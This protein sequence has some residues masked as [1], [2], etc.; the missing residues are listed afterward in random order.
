METVKRVTKVVLGFSGKTTAT[1][2]N[3]YDAPFEGTEIYK[4]G[5]N[6]I[7]GFK[8]NVYATVTYSDNSTSKKYLK[9]DDKLRLLYEVNEGDNTVKLTAVYPDSFGFVY[10]SNTITLKYAKCNFD[11]ADHV[12]ETAPQTEFSGGEDLKT[13]SGE[14]HIDNQTVSWI[15][16]DGNTIPNFASAIFHGSTV[17]YSKPKATI[18]N[19]IGGISVTETIEDNWGRNIWEK[20]YDCSLKPDALKLDSSSDSPHPY[21]VKYV[22]KKDNAIDLDSLV[23]TEFSLFA[24]TDEYKM[25]KGEYALSLEGEFAGYKDKLYGFIVSTDLLGGISRTFKSYGSTPYGIQAMK[26][27]PSSIEVFGE[28]T[29]VYYDTYVSKFQIP[30]SLSFKIK[31]RSGA[32]ETIEATDPR[33]TYSVIDEEGDS[34]PADGKT[35]GQGDDH[36]FVAFTPDINLMDG[37]LGITYPLKWT[38][39]L[40]TNVKLELDTSLQPKTIYVDYDASS[41]PIKDLSGKLVSDVS[42]FEHDCDEHSFNYSIEPEFQGYADVDYEV[43]VTYEYRGVSYSA[44]YT[45]IVRKNSFSISASG[46]DDKSDYY[47]TWRTAFQVPTSI[48]FILTYAN[49][50]SEEVSPADERI[51]YYN[52]SA[53]QVRLTPSSIV[54]KTDRIYIAFDNGKET[55]Y[56]SYQ[57]S[58]KQDPLEGVYL[59]LDTDNAPKRVFFSED[60]KTIDYSKVKAYIK[61][62]VEKLGYNEEVTDKCEVTISPSINTEITANYVVTFSTEFLGDTFSNS[63]SVVCIPLAISSIVPDKA[64]TE[65]YYDTWLKPF[66]LPSINF[67]IHYNDGSSKSVT[68][69]YE[70]FSFYADADKTEVLNSGIIVSKSDYIYFD[71]VDDNGRKGSGRYSISANRDYIAALS[72]QNPNMEITKGRKPSDYAFG[73]TATYASGASVPNWH[74]Y[75]IRNSSSYI[76]PNDGNSPFSYKDGKVAIE[77]IDNSCQDASVSVSYP[78]AN[79]STKAVSI[80]DYGELKTAINKGKDG[81]DLRRTKV[82]VTYYDKDGDLDYASVYSYGTEATKTTFKPSSSNEDVKRFDGTALEMPSM[83]ANR[84][85]VEVTLSAVQE[86]TGEAVSVSA[87]VS[88]IAIANIAYISSGKAINENGYNSS[89]KTT[90]KIGEKFADS[91]DKSNVFIGYKDANGDIDKVKFDLA[92]A[93]SLLNIN[94][95]PGTALTK[96]GN[97]TVRVASVFDSSVYLEYGIRVIPNVEYSAEGT[98]T[99]DLKPYKLPYDK[100]YKVGSEE[101]KL[102]SGTY[103]LVP[104]E[105]VRLSNGVIQLTGTLN[106]AYGGGGGVSIYG[107]LNNVGDK[108]Q[109]GTV[110]LFRDFIPPV[111]G[112]SNIIVKFPCYDAKSSDMVNKCHFGIRFGHNNSLNRLFLSGNPEKPNYDIHSEEPNWNN[113]IKDDE[114]DIRTSEGD[115]SYFP[116]VSQAK[117]GESENAVIGYDVVSDSKLLVLKAKSGK[118]RT[119]YFRTPTI[120]ASIDASGNVRDSID[121]STLSQEEYATAMSNSPIAG[122]S[123]KSIVNFNGDTMFVSNE[124]NVVGLDLEGIVGD[125]QRQA[126]SRSLYIDAEFK[127]KDI[128][129]A[130]LFTAGAYCF[131]STDEKM[132]VAHRDSKS[133]ESRQYEW[134]PVDATKASAFFED[135][136]GSVF[137]GTGDGSFYKITDGKYS[138]SER[139]FLNKDTYD[140]MNVTVGANGSIV[141]SAAI[142]SKIDETWKYRHI[143]HDRAS[144]NFYE[145][146]C[147]IGDGM[148]LHVEGHNLAVKADASFA[149]LLKELNGSSSYYLSRAGER[150]II[151]LGDDKKLLDC[152]ENYKSLHLVQTEASEGNYAEY[153]VYDA[154]GNRVEMDKVSSAGLARRLCGEYDIL[155]VA[156]GEFRLKGIN[157]QMFVARMYK[158]NQ[159]D[160]KGEL[161][162]YT[163]IFSYFKTGALLAETSNYDKSI[164]KVDVIN[165]SNLPNDLRVA[166]ISN[167]SMSKDTGK[168]VPF[169][170]GTLEYDLFSFSFVDTN[171]GKN[172]VP[173]S[174]TIKRFFG[175]QR[176]FE[177]AFMSQNDKNSVLPSI[178]ITYSY[179]RLSNGS[180]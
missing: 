35:I 106:D 75:T 44:S 136:D 3:V 170:K 157:G 31:Y 15:G 169:P 130:L 76:N 66:A 18:E 97:Y 30:T 91:T 64:D 162:K 33:L 42:G 25:G 102:A 36:F 152:Y 34:E 159:A 87:Y 46:L 19:F 90:Y 134:W 60:V 121:G 22:T 125:S 155:S 144:D 1:Y 149:Y 128:S 27:G 32:S 137:Y 118:E 180:N 151:D 145:M 65:N 119:I 154:I 165:G 74:N 49:G 58:V 156:N 2:C 92:G 70:H 78:M 104:S 40:R 108:S 68:A 45:Q 173:K 17:S 115:Y 8:P 116:D 103:A 38:S 20:S 10:S 16:D 72:A 69:D 71:Y 89:F 148:G 29:S 5:D 178:E 62:T 147:Q 79:P 138:D 54:A 9:D 67:T 41:F 111:S 124:N 126:N 123:P 105:Y 110:V 171:F 88:V 7:G 175:A 26:E 80:S 174:Y 28:D 61:S 82:K 50:K 127:G 63:Y 100:T 83:T 99:V 21:F 94:P 112:E 107:Y 57:I 146:L 140:V 56:G 109:A 95:I 39:D 98:K 4:G 160:V 101:V 47:N 163:P 114:D 120:V 55:V 142:T 164:Y 59:D 14:S 133:S 176:Y 12:V 11:V 161:V 77:F 143:S 166:Y 6:G 13:V 131:L 37:S 150:D 81:I 86:F 85:S 177:L 96:E 51:S 24:G 168:E 167:Q 48:K 158:E 52:D 117:Y 141:T 73:F 113:R 53:R 23:T 93:S 132:Y 122:V 84:L 179:L 172:T 129:N 153:E 43:T 139:L 135:T